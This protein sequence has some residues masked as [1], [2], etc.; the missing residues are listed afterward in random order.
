MG[1][2]YIS[3][4]DDEGGLTREWTDEEGNITKKRVGSS[5][6]QGGPTPDAE[7]TKLI[8]DI[9]GTVT[10]GSITVNPD[11][12]QPNDMDAAVGIL[13]TVANKTMGCLLYT[14][15]SPRD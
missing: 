3:L 10:P 2:R 12:R 6:P 5:V 9:K 15:P 1:L 8:N 7:K 4:P 11:A 14:S 13:N